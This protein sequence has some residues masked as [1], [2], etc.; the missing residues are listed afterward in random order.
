MRMRSSQKAHDGRK[1]NGA[2]A[3][4]E[5]E[6]DQNAELPKKKLPRGVPVEGS[7]RVGP[8][9]PGRCTSLDCGMI[10]SLSATK[11]E[12]CIY[13]DEHPGQPRRMLLSPSTQEPPL[14]ARRPTI[15]PR[16]ATPYPEFPTFMLLLA[17]F[18]TR[19]RDFLET[20]AR[21]FLLS[22]NVGRHLEGPSM[23]AFDGEYSVIA[24][25]YDVLGRKEA[26]VQHARVLKDEIECA[27]RLKFGPTMWVSQVDHGVVARFACDHE[28]LVHLPKQETSKK[29]Q[30]PFHK[31]MRGELEI[32]VMADGSH[33]YFPGQ[34]TVIRFRLVG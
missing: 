11:C 24:M 28:V 4:K 17:E 5:K 18:Y 2:D 23:F 34:R 7:E 3:G 13:R 33:Q 26:V 30:P 8:T 20:Q 25:D 14:K 1:E 31:V 6:E 32:A 29:D 22:S 16:Q 9:P 21:Y 19:L 27:G 10:V 15:T 12:Q